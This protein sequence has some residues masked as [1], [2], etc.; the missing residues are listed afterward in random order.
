[1]PSRR[2]IAARD[3]VPSCVPGKGAS[4]PMRLCRQISPIA[5][6]PPIDLTR[7]PSVEVPVRSYKPPSPAIPYATDAPPLPPSKEA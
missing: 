6:A 7:L 5:P 4:T 2:P 3:G 1:M